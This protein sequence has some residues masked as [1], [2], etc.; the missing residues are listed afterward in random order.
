M[1][2]Y[3]FTLANQVY[4]FGLRIVIGLQSMNSVFQASDQVTRILQTRTAVTGGRNAA[5]H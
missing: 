4:D 2:K 3:I 1:I 5:G